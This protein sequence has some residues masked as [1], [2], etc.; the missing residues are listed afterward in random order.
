MTVAMI[1]VEVFVVPKFNNS[2]FAVEFAVVR[3]V[4]AKKGLL[5]VSIRV[6]FAVPGPTVPPPELG[7]PV[8]VM[9]MPTPVM[10]MPEDQL[11]GEPVVGMMILSPSTAVCVGPLI[12][13]FTSDW[14]HEAAV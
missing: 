11:Q 13:A 5:P 14:L 6:V 2:T 10:A 1:V 4:N 12:T 8:P 3:P 9:S 7:V